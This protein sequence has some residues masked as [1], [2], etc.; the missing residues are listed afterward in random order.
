MTY[1][2]KTIGS[3]ANPA[4]GKPRRYQTRSWGGSDSI[5]TR[6]VS[7]YVEVLRYR[8]EV[9]YIH[10][11]SWQKKGNGKWDWVKRERKSHTLVP[12]TKLVRVWS[13]VTLQSSEQSVKPQTGLTSIVGLIPSAVKQREE[14]AGLN[15]EAPFES[16]RNFGPGVWT[17]RKPKRARLTE[18]P[19]TLTASKW[20]DY[21][22][23]G[24]SANTKT[25]VPLECWAPKATFG[26]G[27][28]ATFGASSWAPLALL[29]A[30]DHYKLINKIAEAVKGSDFN[31]AV[32]LA[33]LN[34]SVLM[35]GNAA[36]RIA[37]YMHYMK[38]GLFGHAFEALVGDPPKGPARRL[39]GQTVT[40]EVIAKRHLE[41]V[42]GWKP[43]LNDAKTGAES[44]AEAL[45]V[46]QQKT[47]RAAVSKRLVTEDVKPRGASCGFP[48]VN[49]HGV[50]TRQHRRGVIVRF[51][52]KPSL[53]KL[54]GLLDPE[55]VLWEK[56]SFSFVADWF[57][58]IGDWL[59]ARGFAQ[60]L[61]ATIIQSEK[62]T[63]VQ[64][65]PTAEPAWV[66]PTQIADTF[67]PA[68][69]RKVEFE[70]KILTSFDVP[71][72]TVVPLNKA[73]SWIH[74][75]NAVALL[76]ARHSGRGGD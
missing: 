29:E 71:S 33:E 15:S 44:L 39:R 21:H 52:E 25:L 43:L 30:S 9:R 37:R 22:V 46:P 55:V 49:Y 75:T 50:A 69:C 1:G 57:I 70:R 48:M 8:K 73:L 58:P 53:P 62:K 6:T 60:G 18:N 4:P 10:Y 28:M 26:G 5:V 38:K 40:S 67:P 19:Y 51:R 34:E 27:Y 72:P 13:I 41:N 16:V 59:Q 31:L 45:N 68:D 14:V 23:T 66:Y 42:Y 12:Y 54:L 24:L 7:K 74:A 56:V 76:V 64:H 20:F 61:D 36:T 35:I 11:L 3:F 65:Q 47:Y 17:E 32:S 63:G 2:S